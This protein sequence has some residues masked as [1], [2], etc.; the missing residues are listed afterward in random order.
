MMQSMTPNL[1]VHDVNKTVEYYREILGFKQEMSVPDSGKLDWAMMKHGTIEIMFQTLLSI[2]KDV[3]ALKGVQP[4]GAC[5]LFVQVADVKKLHATIKEK[6]DIIVDL[7]TTF[8]GMDEFTI[9][10]LNGY[11]LTFATPAKQ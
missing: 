2:E 5:T 7:N 9:K 8:Y 6:V 10:D 11:F 1:I 3:P 4:G